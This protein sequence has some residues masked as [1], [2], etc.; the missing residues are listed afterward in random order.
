M[1]GS[2][3]FE[4]SGWRKLFPIRLCVSRRSARAR[5]LLF[6]TNT[7]LFGGA[8]RHLIDLLQ[9]LSQCDESIRLVIFCA[10]ADPFSAR[11]PGRLAVEVIV[12]SRRYWL[13][14]WL[15]TVVRYRPAA[16]IFVHGV[17][18]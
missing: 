10:N 5:V 3:W 1:S 2:V 14:A 18:S 7:P 6:A 16:V 9:T 12:S 15:K 17:L 8:E 4:R 11:L 13:L